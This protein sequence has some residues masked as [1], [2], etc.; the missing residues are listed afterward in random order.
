MKCYALLG[1]IIVDAR[2]FKFFANFF[3]KHFVLSKQ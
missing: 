1:I 2:F 3:I